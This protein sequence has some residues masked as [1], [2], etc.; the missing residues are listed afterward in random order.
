VICGGG[1]RDRAVT[2][3]SSALA[4]LVRHDDRIVR[5]LDPPFDRTQRDPGY[6]RA[7]PPGIRENGGQ[8]SH[9]AAW[10]GIAC[11]LLGDGASAKAIFDRLNPILQSQ[12][13]QAAERYAIEP[14]V[15]AGDIGAGPHL[16]RGGWSWYTGAAAW[17]WRLAVEHILGVS[18]TEGRI[19][20]APCIPADWSGF[21]AIFEG[22]GSIAIEVSRGRRARRTL[23]GRPWD[24]APVAFPGTGRRSR[25]RVVL[26]DRQRVA[27]SVESPSPEPC[28]P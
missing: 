11:A 10:L 27:N 17:T 26:A 9:A 5:L 1:G 22:D 14:Y 12:S 8:Y 21:S 13:A 4:Q 28:P 25:I 19:A 20:I 23:D 18:L 7:Y 3:V 15:V 16:G 2:A 6:I 24:G